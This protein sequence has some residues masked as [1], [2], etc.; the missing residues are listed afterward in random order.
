MDVEDDRGADGETGP[1]G[2]PALTASD[3]DPG[4]I[5]LDPSFVLPRRVAY[6]ARR[7]PGRPFLSEVTGRSLSYGETWHQVT[8]WARWLRDLGAR[9][10]D[11]IITMLP[12]S[13]DAVVLW[14]TAGCLG[15]VEVPVDPGLRGTF[16]QHVLTSS[17]GRLCL[18]R[19]EFADLVRS[20]GASGLDVMALA[21]Q[22]DPVPVASTREDPAGPA[23][24]PRPEE[25]GCVI[26][27]S[28][29][30]GLPKGVLLSWAQFSATIGRIPRSWL[31]DRD[32][33]YCCHPMF[34]VTGRTPLLSMADVGGRVVLRERFSASA[35]LAD[36]RA[37]GC[38][39]TTAYA[40]LMLATPAQPD[41][42]DNPLRVVFGS[43]PALDAR[44]AARFGVRATI[45]AYGSTE[46]GFPLLLRRPPRDKSRR[47][48]GTPRPGYAARIVDD[49][50]TEVADGQIGEL[51]IR[52]PARPLVMLEYL[53]DPAATTAAFRGDWYRTG[54]AARRHA[55]GQIEFIDRLR[56]TIRRHGENISS[57]AVEAVVAAEDDVLDCAALGV[58]DAVA[59]Q[60]VALA[61]VPRDASAFDPAQLY[62]R[63]G[64]R[65]PR[66]FLP[67]YIV[68]CADLP[69]TTTSKVRKIDLAGQLDLT[70]AWRPA[71][72]RRV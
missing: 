69:R 35:F 7:D 66:A 26:Y 28:G 49:Q 24:L 9:R 18:V 62:E 68:I 29:T 43:H 3:D 34:H 12:A 58:P 67:T 60:E 4:R 54:D 57:A 71:R 16:L 14:L 8:R 55:D 15:A 31:S 61:V 5:G 13:V 38:T 39:T 11:R 64:L 65:L 2:W 46:A 51:E 25:P 72:A 50:G 30:T 21:R 56:D 59:G 20:S 48:C 36:V 17:G 47:W 27:T 23:T 53:G 10:G 44:F 63:L 32:C 37:H 45:G 6:W 40:A 42:A 70:T 52:V 1:D 41:D 19:P 22:R 33:A